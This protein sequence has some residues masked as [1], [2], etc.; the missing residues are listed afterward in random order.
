MTTR[1]RLAALA[2]PLS[3]EVASRLGVTISFSDADGD[4]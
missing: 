2:V 4:S 1:V 3:T